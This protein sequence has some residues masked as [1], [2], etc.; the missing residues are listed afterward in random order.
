MEKKDIHSHFTVLETSVLNKKPNQQLIDVDEINLKQNCVVILCGNTTK[1]PARA[2]T[3]TKY[4]Y[5]WLANSNKQEKL[6]YYS[7]FYPADQPLLNTFAENP[8]YDYK[9]LSDT[10][11]SSIVKENDNLLPADKI[12]HNF[13]KVTFFGHSVGGLIM[14]NITN[15][16]VNF[17]ITNNY[18]DY[19][20]DKILTSIKFIAYSPYKTVDLPIN[21]IYIAPLYDS[22][23][24]TKKCL[25]KVKKNNYVSTNDKLAGFLK[26][27]YRYK[28]YSN[29]LEKIT[30]VFFDTQTNYVSTDRTFV[31][32]PNLL[33]FDGVCEDHN[34][35]GIINSTNNNPAK[36]TAGKLSTEF[37]NIVMRYC[38][39]TTKEN[40]STLQLY[41]I[42]TKSEETKSKPTENTVTEKQ[43]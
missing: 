31:A 37:M 34:L 7:I 16:F 18:S 28:Y 14:N 36:T 13:N 9:K 41:N 30:P 25:D 32:I 10:I 43:K 11:F 27:I 26:Q 40:I 5:D 6:K 8:S 38:T 15:E 4:V 39:E 21:A 1:S 42:I 33:Y 2:S 23:G 20:I 19:D 29:Y 3:Y 12:S 24:S 22:L 35:A 17:L